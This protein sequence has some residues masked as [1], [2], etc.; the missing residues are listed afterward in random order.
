MTVEQQK[1]ADHLVKWHSK[2]SNKKNFD[3]AKDILK[4]MW[5]KLKPTDIV[6]TL[7]HPKYGLFF[8]KHEQMEVSEEKK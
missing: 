5:E 3:P 1:D 2:G 6:A 4:R 7:K 8:D